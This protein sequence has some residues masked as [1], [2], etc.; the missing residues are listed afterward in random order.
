MQLHEDLDT[1]EAKE[2]LQ[3]LKGVS[4]AYVVFRRYGTLENSGSLIRVWQDEN[5]SLNKNKLD[6]QP[7]LKGRA[8]ENNGCGGLSA[9]TGSFAVD[10]LCLAASYALMPGCAC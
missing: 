7:L 9:C 10:N 5:K 8:R 3:F 2:H 6:L 1:R 4:S